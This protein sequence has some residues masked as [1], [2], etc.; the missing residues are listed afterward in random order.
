MP[1]TMKSRL[2]GWARIA[3]WVALLALLHDPWGDLGGIVPER[4][5][6]LERAV[7]GAALVL[8]GLIGA[9]GAARDGRPASFVRAALTA[10]AGCV[11]AALIAQTVAG[12]WAAVGITVVGLA[13]YCAGFDL[14]FAV[15]PRMRNADTDERS[16][17]SFEE[18]VDS[19]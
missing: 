12:R 18:R 10:P 5:R 3:G 17:A 13:A 19:R 7:L 4:V 16:G 15:F 6:W 14:F 1:V 11:A 8:G 2:L 9:E